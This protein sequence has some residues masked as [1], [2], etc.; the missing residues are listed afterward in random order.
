MSVQQI[1]QELRNLS[2]E[3]R[4][5]LFSHFPEDIEDFIDAYLL[6]KALAEGDSMP[7]EEFL[8]TCFK[9]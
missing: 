9:D 1:E 5:E 8:K 6:E 3:E 4:H 7:L 2:A